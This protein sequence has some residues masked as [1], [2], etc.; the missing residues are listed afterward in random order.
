MKNEKNECSSEKYSYI[1]YA[2][3]RRRL[4]HWT[5][6]RWFIS[7]YIIKIRLLL[8]VPCIFNSKILLHADILL[9]IICKNQWEPFFI[10]KRDIVIEIKDT[11]SQ[12]KHVSTMITTTRICLLLTLAEVSCGFFFTFFTFNKF[13]MHNVHCF[14]NQYN[15]Y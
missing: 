7:V 2:V 4:W 5:K 9:K 11:L 14:G 13:S 12:E 10:I 1:L 15:Y 8:I 6:N 3:C